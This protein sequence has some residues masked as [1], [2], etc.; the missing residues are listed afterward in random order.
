MEEKFNRASF[1]KGDEKGVKLRRNHV[2]VPVWKNIRE[3][4]GIKNQRNRGERFDRTTIW[5]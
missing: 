5:V 1:Q 2:G 3:D 4:S